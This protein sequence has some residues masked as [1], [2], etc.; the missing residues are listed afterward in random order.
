MADRTSAE[1]FGYIF[2]MLAEECERNKERAVRFW[3]KAREY[4]FSWYQMDC[5]AAL[6]KLGL[7]RNSDEGL[8]YGPD[9][10]DV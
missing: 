8:R 10:D 4:D 9:G 3:Q 5:D 2:D 1:L 6:L 7:A